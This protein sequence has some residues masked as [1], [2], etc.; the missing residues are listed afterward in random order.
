MNIVTFLTDSLHSLQRLLSLTIFST[1]IT[2]ER[3]ILTADTNLDEAGVD[4]LS[5]EQ[6]L[7]QLVPGKAF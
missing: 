7:C 1:A 5:Q 3:K 6:Q 2:Y 4:N